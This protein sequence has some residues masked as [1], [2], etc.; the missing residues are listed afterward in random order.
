MD[1]E[2]TLRKLFN[3]GNIFE[4]LYT[5]TYDREKHSG[6]SCIQM[7]LSRNEVIKGLILNR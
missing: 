6:T 1:F 2:K 5:Q 7:Y 4:F 3:P